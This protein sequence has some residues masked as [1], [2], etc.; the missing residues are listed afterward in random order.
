MSDKRTW[1][2][3]HLSCAVCAQKIEDV[4]A[5]KPG[6]A[7]AFVDYTK[8]QITIHTQEHQDAMF[9]DDLIKTAK[10]VEPSLTINTYNPEKR[11]VNWNLIRIV[12]ALAFFVA[13]LML[14][15]NWLFFVSWALGGYE[16]LYRAL[17]NIFHGK[18]FDEYF[19]MSIATI[20]AVLIGEHAEA[21]AVMLFY[22]IGEFFQD[23]A[24]QKSRK[25]ILDTLDL[26]VKQA[27]L[28]F[29]GTLTMV[30][31]IDIEVGSILRILPGEKIPLDGIIVKGSTS[32]DL[33]SLTGE[34]L[35]SSK[36]T[37]DEV[38]SGSLNLSGAIDI[39]TTKIYEESTAKKII[40]LITE[41]SHSK[42]KTERFI[43]TFARYYTPLVVFAA[44]AI[45]IIPPLFTG[46]WHSW[47]YRS[48]VFLVVSC[49]CAL[50]ISVPLTYFGALG[51]SAR[52]GILIKGG[53][54][55]D[56]VHNADTL[57][58]DKTGTLTT[59]TF[60]LEEVTIIGSHGYEKE[61]LISLVSALER[62]STHPLARAFDEFTTFFEA[63]ESKEIAG[64]GLLGIVDNKSVAVGNIKLLKELGLDREPHSHEDKELFLA[65][66]GELVATFSLSDTIRRNA[67]TTI[68]K[69]RSF[70]LRYMAIISGDRQSAVE[71]VA[72]SLALDDFHAQLLPQEKH[73]IVKE[74]AKKHPNLIYV[75][76]GIN[77]APSLKYS[78][79]GIA[80]GS[81]STD[82]ARQ[83]SDIVITS[84]NLGKLITLKDISDKTSN[85][86][87]Q[88]IALALGVKAAVM[89]L[90][91]FGF[92]S[93]WLAVIADTGVTIL[94][95]FNA[96]R[97]LVAKVEH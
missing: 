88:N 41:S 42:A 80:L 73:Q 72:K 96:L 60:H 17:K 75:G 61:Y 37:G 28:L 32:L 5:K 16:V 33:S 14:N 77:D 35:P 86:A 76:D 23:A 7:K 15:Q 91:L 50:V 55:L 24:V 19:L 64:K 48:L 46:D 87:K 94:A 38:L 54:F 30:D 45:A 27:R 89:L 90:T 95:I 2:V 65:L 11:N 68:Q 52:E 71:N 40:Q 6:V 97:I 4:L 44:L 66:D 29:E 67:F 39:Q 78:K 51:R 12:A 9:Y 69:L 25:S 79:V 93:M 62:L 8:K 13:G 63:R 85:L 56:A 10:S 21:A 83:S 36:E 84:D 58:F 43:T 22:L 20:G 59:G 92:A 70:G 3:E 53:N 49:P 18:I 26:Q 74:L 47:I 34:S 1:D 57:L 81:S 82:A 31:C